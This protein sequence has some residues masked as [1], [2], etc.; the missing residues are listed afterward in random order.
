M[1][2]KIRKATDVGAKLTLG[3][4]KDAAA[5]TEA[6]KERERLLRIAQ[7]QLEAEE[8]AIEE[9]KRQQQERQRQAREA[10]EVARLK[11]E[12]RTKRDFAKAIQG[13]KRR[14]EENEEFW[15]QIAE[16]RE[17]ILREEYEKELARLKKLQ[18][19]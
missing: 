11:E 15:R 12:L 2:I 10:M 3:A 8:R 7:E 4:G 16:G 17:R 19:K 9:Q 13:L 5:L 6:Q 14:V 18:G 1:T